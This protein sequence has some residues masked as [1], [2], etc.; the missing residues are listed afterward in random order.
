MNKEQISRRRF[1][2]GAGLS[3]LAASGLG[4]G[5]L[6]GCAPR[7]NEANAGASDDGL[8]ETGQPTSVGDA[9]AKGDL[10][11]LGP[12]PADPENIEEELTADV[13]IVGCGTAGTCA[14]RAAAEDGASVIVVEKA[15]HAAVCRSG[16]WAV[17][18]GE[19][20]K[21]WERGAGQANYVDPD[22]VVEAV[23]TECQY[24]PNRT[25]LS[26]WAHNNGEVFDWF[27]AAKPD[28]FISAKSTDPL[29]AVTSEEDCSLW[30][31]H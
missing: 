29:P 7:A 16:Q 13:V 24:Y 23:M 1:L 12:E 14:A 4:A 6:S 19:T 30:V 21:R 20:N 3:A 26:K 31:R 22:E 18:G 15:D 11:W 25:L 10:T 28:L 17:I 5:L 27:I 9:Q 2:K 8:A